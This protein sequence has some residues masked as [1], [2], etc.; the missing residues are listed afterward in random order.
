MIAAGFLLLSGCQ[1][2]NHS[3]E[4]SLG[5]VDPAPLLAKI[6]AELKYKPKPEDPAAQERYVRASRLAAK[7]ALAR[8]NS[9]GGGQMPL[10]P[11][12][13]VELR[14]I[15]KEGPVELG[16]D[17][18]LDDQNLGFVPYQNTDVGSLLA[19]AGAAEIRSGN[20]ADG[21]E[22]IILSIKWGLQVNDPISEIGPLS[23]ERTRMAQE[24][25]M[26]P[27]L[28]RADKVKILAAYP[29]EAELAEMQR[30]QIKLALE[31]KVYALAALEAPRKDLVISRIGISNGYAPTVMKQASKSPILVP[32][33]GTL[34]RE[35]TLEGLIQLAKHAYDQAD[36]TLPSG[37]VTQP[38]MLQ[39]LVKW[40]PRM[41]MGLRTSSSKERQAVEKK[42]K[43]YVEEMN[44]GE[45][46]LGRQFLQSGFQVGYG[47]IAQIRQTIQN[48][49]A[50][51]DQATPA[52]GR[53]APQLR[54]R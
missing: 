27:G 19:A 4:V 44:K 6:P 10:L 34:D 25:F 9:Y 23:Y 12:T 37:M 30:D 11:G 48:L 53:Q 28:T 20:K 14:K 36:V 26:M 42:V 38:P 7:D 18:L 22:D 35:A 33:H 3:G 8:Q 40:V 45:N 31:D 16:Y 49:R 46:T 2:G 32:P 50:S 15:L 29:T 54:A 51:I 24:V 13:L 52:P 5:G 1:P 43:I 21:I 39:E 47:G 41:P 17:E